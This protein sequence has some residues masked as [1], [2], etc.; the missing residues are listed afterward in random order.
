MASNTAEKIKDV[1]GKTRQG[2][3]SLVCTNPKWHHS[4]FEAGKL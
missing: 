2:K 3:E 1:E 4:A